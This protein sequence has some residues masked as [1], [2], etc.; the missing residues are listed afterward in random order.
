MEGEKVELCSLAANASLSGGRVPWR[1]KQMDAFQPGGEGRGLSSNASG[2]SNTSTC[3][4]AYSALQYSYTRNLLVAGSIHADDGQDNSD[5][6]S[7]V[8]TIGNMQPATCNR[9]IGELN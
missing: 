1:C 7:L 3:S 4:P 8:T 9:G 6:R 2:A 5:A